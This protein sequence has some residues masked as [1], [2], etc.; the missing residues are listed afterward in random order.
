M[1]LTINKIEPAIISIINT[2]IE[3][4]EIDIEEEINPETRLIEDLG[5]SSVDFVELFVRIEEQFQRKLG[6]HQL[7]MAEDK[8]VDDLSLQQLINFIEKAN[9][10]EININKK[11]SDS[12][13][14]SAIDLEKIDQEKIEKFRQKIPAPPL[15]NDQNEN[16]NLPAVFLLC[17]SRSGSTLLRVI[18]A[19]NSQIFAPP[20]LHLL[21]FDTLVNRHKALDNEGNRHLL[22]GTIRAIMQAKK[23]T[24]EEAEKIMKECE[25]KKLKCSDFYRLLQQWI[26]PEILVDKTPSNSYH[27]NFLKSIENLFDSA[28]YIHLTRHPYGM[29][30]SFEDAKMDELLPFMQSNDFS[31]REY[32]E[33]AWLVC[34]QN[35]L[36]FLEDIPANRKL[37]IKFEDLVVIPET[38]IQQICSFVGVD[39]QSQMLNPYEDKNQRMTDG[40]KNASRMSG[41]LKFHL[42]RQIEPNIAFRWR[43]YHTVDFLGDLTWQLAKSFGYDKEI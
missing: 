36:T 41:D 18:L 43:Q 27:I 14:F 19:G 37:R 9:D 2:L 13:D 21:S 1:T 33:L 5:F 12:L 3:E 15:I 22:D 35:I 30:K 16:K 17:P 28:L 24:V 4:W 7:I 31:R 6:F 20:E 23:C 26:Y 11:N 32:G 34:H 40:V 39:F 42:H 10:S 8:Y 29:I 25:Q 38:I